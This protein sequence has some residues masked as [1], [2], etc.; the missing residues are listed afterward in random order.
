MLFIDIFSISFLLYSFRRLEL[1]VSMI[2][3]ASSVDS[4]TK[5]RYICSY[6][7]ASLQFSFSLP[8]T[9]RIR[10]YSQHCVS[11]LTTRRYSGCDFCSLL[12]AMRRHA[13]ALSLNTSCLYSRPRFA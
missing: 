8:L 1:Y 7:T 4:F 11:S 2:S 6:F 13:T 10:T 12:N 5:S 9:P 3:F